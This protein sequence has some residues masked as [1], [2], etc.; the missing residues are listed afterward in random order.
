MRMTAL[1]TEQRCKRLVLAVLLLLFLALAVQAHDENHWSDWW[2][3]DAQSML[4]LRHWQEGGWINNRL[5]FKPQGYAKVVDL[6]DLPELRH[7]AHGISPGSSPRVGPRLLYTHYPAGYL[8]PYALLFKLGIDSIF[9]MRLLSIAISV[10]ALGL[11]YRLFSRLSSPPVALIAVLFYAASP[12]FLAYADALA[13]Q[14]LDDLLRFGFML[15][16]LEANRAEPGRRR[17][18]L[19]L[20]AWLIEWILSLCSFDSVLFV[21]VW[22]VGFDLLER[23]GFRWRR[24]LIFALAPL[25]AQAL[26]I[27]QNVWYLGWDD[28]ITDLVDTFVKKSVPGQGGSVLGLQGGRTTA[29]LLAL[30]SNFYSIYSPGLVLPGLAAI[31]LASRT[32]CRG[33]DSAPLPSFGLLTLLL[34]CGLGFVLVLPVAAGMSYEGRQMLPC[35]ALLVGGFSWLVASECWRWIGDGRR[36]AEDS[37]GR[38]PGLAI[39]GG[40]LLIAFWCWFLVENRHVPI[41]AGADAPDN[42]FAK[43]LR[44]MPTPYEPVYFDSGGFSEYYNAT[45]VAGYPQIQ[46]D[47]EYYIGSRP[48]VC[49]DQPEALA[50]DLATMIRLAPGRFSPV[51]LTDSQAK[52]QQVVTVLQRQG[53]LRSLPAGCATRFDK[54]VLDFSQFIQW[55]DGQ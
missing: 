34:V 30:L 18:M 31:Y 49:F 32:M 17:N 12:M 21:Y 37:T 7:L 33:G 50:T 25:L 28:A 24:Y 43:D 4:S 27:L 38:G 51:V 10:V 42:L 8:I 53:L 14:P 55:P 48:I 16:V 2:F 1:T 23:R 26:L 54:F 41:W 20:T 44:A 52:M 15:A 40:V 35:V 6:F 46:P 29:T 45:Y 36:A 19:L 47:T 13:N 5:L 9:A 3:G 11:M 39:A 22:L